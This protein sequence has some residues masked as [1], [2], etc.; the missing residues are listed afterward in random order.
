MFRQEVPVTVEALEISRREEA[1]RAQKRAWILP[2]IL[3]R[4]CGGSLD[5]A[6]VCTSCGLAHLNEDGILDCLPGARESAATEFNGAV[7]SHGYDGDVERIL[8]A[9]ETTG[10]MALDCGAGLRPDVRSH[11]V[12]TEIFPYPT[13]DILAV[14]ERLPFRDSSF[15]AVLSLH[16]LEHVPDPFLCARE[17]CR[18]LKPGGKLFAVTPM[19]VPEHGFPQHFFNPTRQGLARLFGRTPERAR[20]F[21]PAMGHPINGVWSVIQLYRQSLPEPQRSRFDSMT[22]AELLARPIEAWIGEGIAT[23]MPENTRVALA[24][25]FCIEFVKE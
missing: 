19:I 25:N 14:N 22:I 6:G 13:T 3:C 10:G 9:V 4:H 20:I 8:A 23:A 21:I 17:L 16:V 11:V 5:A 1:V 12:T 15:D 2:R 7:C 18:V 24:A